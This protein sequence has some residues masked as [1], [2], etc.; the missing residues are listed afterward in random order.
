MAV[1]YNSVTF[2]KHSNISIDYT[3]SLRAKSLWSLDT[4][5]LRVAL[6]SHF[7]ASVTLPCAVLWDSVLISWANL[8]YILSVYKL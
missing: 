1:M 2:C 5:Y 7:A 8:A 3:C 6:N 4:H